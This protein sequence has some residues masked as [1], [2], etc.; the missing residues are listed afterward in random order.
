MKYINS[1]KLIRTGGFTLQTSTYGH[2]HSCHRTEGTSHGA[3]VLPT[4]WSLIAIPRFRPFPTVF[5]C[6][7]GTVMC[8]D[9]F[10]WLLVLAFFRDLFEVIFYFNN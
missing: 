7:T 10:D 9:S 2:E 6:D 8:M 3:I 5:S 4:F 1:R